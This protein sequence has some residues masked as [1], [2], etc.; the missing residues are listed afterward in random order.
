MNRAANIFEKGKKM[1]E[2]L[3]LEVVLKAKADIQDAAGLSKGDKED[4]KFVARQLARG[5]D[6]CPGC[7]GATV[8]ELE[9][10]LRR[11]NALP[12]ID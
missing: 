9:N 3:E 8:K 4:L 1:K 12:T 2:K 11:I 10:E 7:L 6:T 5:M